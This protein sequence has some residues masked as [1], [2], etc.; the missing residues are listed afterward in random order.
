MDKVYSDK[1]ALNWFLENHEGSVICVSNGVEFTADHY[2]A[3]NKFF[4]E[5]EKANNA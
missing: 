2:P 5:Q 3:A 4:K 1:E